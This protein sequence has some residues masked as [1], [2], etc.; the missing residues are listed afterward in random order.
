MPPA[1]SPPSCG[2]PPAAPAPAPAAGAVMPPI[3]GGV[4]NTPAPPTLDFGV[5]VFQKNKNPYDELVCQLHS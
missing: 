3:A 5:A 4:G 1:K 2:A